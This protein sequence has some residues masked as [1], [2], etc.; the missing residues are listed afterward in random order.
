MKRDE[1]YKVHMNPDDFWINQFEL[2]A[3]WNT[4]L[5]SSFRIITIAIFLMSFLVMFTS[6]SVFFDREVQAR[7]LNEI[8]TKAPRRT[9]KTRRH[10]GQSTKS[11][12]EKHT[13]ERRLYQAARKIR[14]LAQQVKVALTQLKSILGPEL[15]TP[16]RKDRR[17]GEQ[18]ATHIIST[19]LQTSKAL[20]VKKSLRL[21]EHLIKGVH[22]QVMMYY[23]F[24]RSTQMPTSPATL[25]LRQEVW[26]LLHADQGIFQRFEGLFCLR[27]SWRLIIAS[28]YHTLGDPTR[29]SLHQRHAEACPPRPHI[30]NKVD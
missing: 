8:K 9:H 27:A 19:H 13:E 15:L 29:S 14:H 26:S 7:P 12:K 10:Q 4:E 30:S 22:A 2:T 6:Q 1:P 28:A 23:Q 17:S 3:R 25:Q 24:P 16:S 11:L 21:I 20:K 5:I 18:S